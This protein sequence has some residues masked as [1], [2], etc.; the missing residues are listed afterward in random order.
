ML[1][2]VKISE[3]SYRW[4]CSI[5]GELQREL[6]RNI[7]IDAAIQHLQKGEGIANLAGAWQMNDSEVQAAKQDL[8][9]GWK[10]WNGRSA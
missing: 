3:E 1:K 5:A 8:R 4:L 7:S 2:T 10:R 6:G 9:K